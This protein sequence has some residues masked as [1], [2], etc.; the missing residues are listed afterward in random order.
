RPWPGASAKGRI[1]MTPS[2]LR[3]REGCSI[4]DI[5]RLDLSADGSAQQSE[6]AEE[7][8][9]WAR[10]RKLVTVIWTALRSNFA[11]KVRR[12]FAVGEA[13]AYVSR[14]GTA[15]QGE[16]CGVHLASTRSSCAHLYG[17][18]NGEN[19]GSAEKTCVERSDERQPKLLITQGGQGSL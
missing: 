16:G 11:S 6:V 17:P 7:I 15:G 18:H 10:A 12:Q 5:G 9:T 19:R 4:R 14:V 2:D 3:C 13:V 1:P 8:A